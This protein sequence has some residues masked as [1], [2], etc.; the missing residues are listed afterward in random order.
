MI[1]VF[2]FTGNV[3]YNAKFLVR[4]ESLKEAKEKASTRDYDG[5]ITLDVFDINIDVESANG[6]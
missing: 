6:Q 5:F 4:A 3:T 2:E 1:E